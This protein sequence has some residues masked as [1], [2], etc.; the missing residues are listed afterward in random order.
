MDI[1]PDEY[2]QTNPSLPFII[3]IGAAL[4]GALIGGITGW[5]VKGNSATPEVVEVPR[6]FTPEELEIACLPLMRETVNTLDEAQLRVTSLDA[7][8]QEKLAEITALEE[9]VEASESSASDTQKRLNYARR[10]L[11]TLQSELALA[12]EDKQE[13]LTRLEETEAT[14]EVTQDELSTQVTQTRL[15]NRRADANQWSSFAG[16]VRLQVCDRGPKKK[17]AKCREELTPYLAKIEPKFEAC[18]RSGSAVPVLGQLDRG[19]DL[20]REAVWLAEDNR[21]YQGWYVLLCD[22]RLPEST[23]R[24]PVEYDDEILFDDFDEED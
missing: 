3:T 12:E 4:A 16:E 15:A 2:P 18:I 22:E 5:I 24:R 14:L 23:K 19:G 21:A 6:D 10:Q 7:Q 11:K 1:E 17:L 8:V 13:L 20:P 9:R